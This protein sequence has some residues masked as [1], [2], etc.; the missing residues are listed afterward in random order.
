M[1]LIPRLLLTSSGVPGTDLRRL[2]LRGRWDNESQ[3]ETVRR[4]LA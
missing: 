3:L 2:R 4:K 1:E